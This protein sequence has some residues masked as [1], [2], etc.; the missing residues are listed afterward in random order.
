MIGDSAEVDAGEAVRFLR[1]VFPAATDGYIGIWVKATDN[2]VKDSYWFPANSPDDA[3]ETIDR[4][5]VHYEVYF[6]LAIHRNPTPSNQRGTIAGSI[7]TPG[8]WLDLDWR[9]D[10][11]H[12]KQNLPPDLDACLSLIADL[13]FKPSI[14]IHSGHGLQVYWLFRELWYFDDDAERGRAGVLG[15]RLT[16]WVRARAKARGWDVDSAHDLGHVFRLPGTIN[17]KRG[18]VAVAVYS[19]CDAR[20][21]P[22]DFDE[23]LPEAEYREQNGHVPSIAD[24]TVNIEA[25]PPFDRF[26]AALENLPKFRGSWE[27]TR[28]DLQ[29]Q[30]NSGWDMSLASIVVPAGWTDQEITDLL[31]ASRRK[32]HAD[33]SLSRSYLEHTLRRA[34]M[35]SG[36]FQ[37]MATL[38]SSGAPDDPDVA[39]R[40]LSGA[41]QAPISGAVR[42]GR[43]GATYALLIDGTEVTLGSSSALQRQGSVRSAIYDATGQMFP[44]VKPN[45]WFKVCDAIARVAAF[46]DHPDGSPITEIEGYVADYVRDAY[47]GRSEQP[48]QAALPTGEPFWRDGRVWIH[49]DALRSH[50]A[51]TRGLRLTNAELRVLLGRAG[52]TGRIVAARPQPGSTPVG[53]YYW[54][55][56]A[57]FPPDYTDASNERA[58]APE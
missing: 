25:S 27:R 50:L 5:A 38:E 21:N 15:A 32:H 10:G 53:R 42:R 3:F 47:A 54:S 7:A 35:G 48:W 30:S 43:D 26:Q 6:H 1:D 44:V 55:G 28:K 22:S 36:H 19:S 40:L 13:P 8:L 24:V 14:V 58:R 49:V 11:A 57:G 4:T 12:K 56:P 31:V 18:A 9:D 51:L 39:L 46:V 34:R 16:S 45:A 20:Y 33:T 29:D 23:F 17:H 2:S 37:A 52:F 41:L